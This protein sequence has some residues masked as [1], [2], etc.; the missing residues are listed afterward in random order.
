LPAGESLPAGPHLP[1]RASRRTTSVALLQGPSAPA[2]TTTSTAGPSV[3]RFGPF[4]LLERLAGNGSVEQYNALWSDA[5][6]SAERLCLLRQLPRE[7]TGSPAFARM[8]AS[9]ARIMGLLQHPNIVRAYAAGAIEGVPYLAL[10]YLDGLTL[11]HVASA[12]RAQRQRLPL[13]VAIYVARE[14]AAGLAYAHGTA[15]GAATSTKCPLRLVHGD[16]RPANV[17]VLRTGEIKLVGFGTTRITSFVGRGGT[18]TTQSRA[19]PVYLSPEQLAGMP[20]DARSDL[21]A[22]GVILWELVCS[23]PLFPTVASTANTVPRPSRVRADVPPALDG[24]IM[25]LLEEAPSRRRKSADDVRRALAELLPA[26]EDA[27][28]ALAAMA[29]GGMDARDSLPRPS[30][31]VQLPVVPAAPGKRK[32]TRVVPSLGALLRLRGRQLA[33]ALPEAVRKPIE[34]ATGLQLVVPPRAAEPRRPTG[35]QPGS[36]SAPRSSVV[37]VARRAAPRPSLLTRLRSQSAWLV[38]QGAVIGLI[39]FVAGAV[40]QQLQVSPALPPQL[41][42]VEPYPAPAMVIETLAVDPAPPPAPASPAIDSK[43]VKKVKAARS[44]S[45]REPR[46]AL[47]R[48]GKLGARGRPAR[49]AR[50]TAH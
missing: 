44:S 47:S 3:G 8:F 30:S 33:E 12:R 27:G 32:V 37:R 5:R 16:L 46:R 9:E 4:R 49:A 11:A 38:A 6:S 29:R 2:P 15:D 35:P 10:E 41:S 45:L 22:L 36:T 20:G 34:K 26:P 21:Y 14:V 43:P 18:G 28:R 24:I 19:R 13:E 40:W 25:H 42:R 17:A 7:L 50:A 1:D 39:A 48:K 31:A 23:Q